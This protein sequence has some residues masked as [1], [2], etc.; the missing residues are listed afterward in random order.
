MTTML[1]LFPYLGFRCLRRATE[2]PVYTNLLGAH[3]PVRVRQDSVS[4][5]CKNS[6]SVVDTFIF[7]W[8]QRG[9]PCSM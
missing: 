8:L 1:K 2:G 3:A 6:E 9:G 5:Q 7:L 4:A